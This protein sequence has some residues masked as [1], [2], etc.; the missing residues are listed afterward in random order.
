[1]TW[2]Q[3][4]FTGS[5]TVDINDLTVVLANYDQTQ[6]G[7][8]GNGLSAVPEPGALRGRRECWAVGLPPGGSGGERRKETR[9]EASQVKTAWFVRWSGFC[10]K[11]TGGPGGRLTR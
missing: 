9:R 5:G 2:A 8:A 6:N 3:G 4:E 1:M 7:A 10:P 11:P